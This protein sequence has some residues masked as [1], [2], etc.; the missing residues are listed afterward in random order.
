MLKKK[1][2]NANK[3]EKIYLLVLGSVLRILTWFPPG[4]RQ[5]GEMKKSPDSLRK[6]VRREVRRF[7][8]RGK[9]HL[10]TELVGDRVG[11]HVRTSYRT[12]I[13]AYLILSRTPHSY[14]IPSNMD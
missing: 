11:T 14:L 3:T 13:D 6:R 7:I 9:C 1:L 12:R 8:F 10:A 5:K 2:T 4:Q